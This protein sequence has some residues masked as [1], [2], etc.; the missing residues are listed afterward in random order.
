MQNKPGRVM[1]PKDVC[2]DRL[3]L[4]L[5]FSCAEVQN[6]EVGSCPLSDVA[7]DPDGSAFRAQPGFDALDQPLPQGRHHVAE[8]DEGA[9]DRQI[10][11][12]GRRQLRER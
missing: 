2:R 12:H 5:P 7:R 4:R 11:L 9:D 8:D 1:P 10:W 3:P 6:S